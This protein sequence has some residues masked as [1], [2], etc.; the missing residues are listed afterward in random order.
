[1]N[2]LANS[3]LP[4][5]GVRRFIVFVLGA[6]L[7]Q[8]FIAVETSGQCSS[9][10]RVKFTATAGA[11]SELFGYSVAA[12]ANVVV[13]GAP[14]DSAA[15]KLGGST[16]VYRRV[17][18]VWVEEAQLTA[19]DAPVGGF[20]GYS[21]AVHGALAVMGA[22]GDDHAGE[23]SGSAYVFRFD[24]DAM[25]WIE[26]AKLTA[27]DAEADDQFGRSVAVHGDVI[28]VGATHDD[29]LS[30]N[31]GAAYVF[32]Y[33]RGKWVQEAKLAPIKG[34]NFLFGHS[35][36][37]SGDVVVVGE[38]DHDLINSE[39]GA[40]HVY[41][42]DGAVWV[43]EAL[44][45]PS[46][47]APQDHFGQS[48]SVDGNLLVVGAFR[49]EHDV[50]EPDAGA[51]YVYRF[52]G[53][54]WIEEAEL[55]ASDAAED[56]S[57]GASFGVS[58]SLDGNVI[59]IG[60]HLGDTAAADAGS[61]YAFR[62]HADSSEWVEE[63]RLT[64]SDAFFLDYFGTAVAVSGDVAVVGARWDDDHGP[65]SGSAYVF[66][67]LSDCNDNDVL[68]AC[69]NDCD[70]DGIINDCDDAS[71][72]WTP[73][74]NGTVDMSDLLVVLANWGCTAPPVCP[75]DING[76]GVVDTVDLR[77]LLDAWGPC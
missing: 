41:R 75:G 69:E 73:C 20:F 6:G 15:A 1:M 66:E 74:D 55:T 7:V 9:N 46:D 53:T 40:T 34:P 57:F 77:A 50:A 63:V 38:P 25:L 17:R 62:F 19:S 4:L 22:W 23:D 61:A 31:G 8:S 68:D 58:V 54:D 39:P 36:S 48:V 21:V 29:D 16:T 12:S 14:Q 67:G 11:E 13:V 71:S 2:R 5:A 51:A 72:C 28:V 64:A 44:L 10:E 35:V 49:H 27:S 47:G 30:D 45:T 26:D 42:F 76:D 37:V 32:R 65:D 18:H 70:G 60:S 59:V 52:D 43:P 3:A 56:D 33:V 24:A